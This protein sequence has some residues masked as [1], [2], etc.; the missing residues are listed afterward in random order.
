MIL[1]MVKSTRDL[2]AKHLKE[3]SVIGVV[4]GSGMQEV[5]RG[6]GEGSRLSHVV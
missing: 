6:W 3:K 5:K 2:S 1:R 4:P